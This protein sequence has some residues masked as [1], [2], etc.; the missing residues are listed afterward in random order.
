MDPSKMTPVWSA[1][2]LGNTTE[3]MLITKKNTKDLVNDAE[4]LKKGDLFL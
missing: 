1:F 4:I 3:G 2:L